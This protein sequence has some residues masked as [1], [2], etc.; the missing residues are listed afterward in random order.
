VVSLL[1]NINKETGMAFVIV[2]HNP[3]LAKRSGRMLQMVDGKLI[4]VAE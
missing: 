3:D 2:T 1:W 4:K